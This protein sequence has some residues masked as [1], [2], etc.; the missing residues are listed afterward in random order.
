MGKDFTLL[1]KDHFTTRPNDIRKG[2]LMLD[3]QVRNHDGV[4]YD[5]VGIGPDPGI[6]PLIEDA[7]GFTIKQRLLFFRLGMTGIKTAGYIHCDQN[8]G[9][10]AG[11]LYL[12]LPHQRYGG[13]SFWRH[14]EFEISEMPDNANDVAVAT[15]RNDSLDESKWERD[16]HVE[17][18]FNRFVTYP[19]RRFHSRYPNV[20]EAATKEEGRLILAVMYDRV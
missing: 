4:D 15:L 6:K 12:N 17:M 18:R 16:G 14:K 19:A 5:G 13:T 3:Y 7:V 8:C 20:I 10:Y 1:V 9:Q 11:V 2:A